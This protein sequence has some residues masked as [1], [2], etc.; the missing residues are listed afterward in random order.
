[1]TLRGR[2]WALVVLGGALMPGTVLAQRAAVT[3]RPAA[4]KPGL[5]VYE[6]TIPQLQEA[7]K[8]GD[9]TSAGL[10]DAYL[11]RIRAYD[12]VLNAIIRVN[13]KA[14]AEAAALD[15]ER[16]QQGPRGPLHGI[17][18]ILKDNYD[19][20]G[21]ETTAG[22]IALAGHLP[23]GDAFVTRKLREAGAIILAKANMDE[24]A[25]GT[26]GLSSVGG[27]TRNPYDPR[28]CPGGSSAGTGAAIAASYAAIGWGTDTCG[29]I[30]IPSAFNSLFG[31]RPSRGLVS[32]DGVVPL[33]HTQDVAGPLTRT[34][35]DLAIAMD[36]TIGIDGADPS[37]AVLRGRELPRF[38]DSLQADALAGMRF[39]VLTNYARGP[40]NDSV[41]GD[42]FR[43]AVAGLK[44]KGAEIIDVTIPEIDTLLSGNRVLRLYEGKNDMIDYLART[45]STTAPGF[46]AVVVSGGL[47]H[48]RLESAMRVAD[49]LQTLDTAAYRSG[50]A[51]QTMIRDSLTRIMD[52]NR[53]D[54]IV[55]PTV[56]RKPAFIGDPQLGSTCNLSA[57]SGL[58]ALS[59][60]AGFT[61]DS[62]PVGIEFLG[63]LFADAHLV[64]IAYAWE[65]AGAK[66]RPPATT[67]PLRNGRARA[68]AVFSL[69]APTV[70]PVRGTVPVSQ[71]VYD[72]TRME[73]RFD[74]RL[75]IP[76]E[77]VYAITLRRADSTGTGPVIQRLSGIGVQ[78]ASGR[79]ALTGAERGWLLGGRLMLTV[80]TSDHP[81]GW[82]LGRLTPPAGG[83]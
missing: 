29:S 30:R 26:T 65:Q 53:L 40:L 24:Q 28:R 12:T 6:A 71:F 80:F 75:P 5:E 41:I 56:R 68:P 63:R 10:V 72:G 43:S 15:A 7:L 76:A 23:A 32:R 17:P 16:A 45:P 48:A 61:E 54:A 38:T 22:W 73:L 82:E 69:L 2:A 11:A 21:L 46:Q 27:Q 51:R 70:A 83:V 39:G 81:A 66:R 67:P 36:A 79:L 35:T 25:R 4:M 14:R 78:R 60:P 33:S 49:T 20:E 52:A 77:R 31:L 1:M 18:V 19:T 50:L 44:A 13:P 42:V 55:Y 58:P 3:R 47:Y 8:R 62:L 37:T 59:A 9:V 74:V 34:V 57:Q 64:K